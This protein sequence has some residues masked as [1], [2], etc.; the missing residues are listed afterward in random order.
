MSANKIKE[1]IQKLEPT[2]KLEIFRWVNNQIDVAEFG[3][4]VG[5]VSVIG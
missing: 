4:G 2:Q 5:G 1:E 3:S